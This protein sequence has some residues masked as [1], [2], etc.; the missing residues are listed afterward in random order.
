[1]A[2]EKFFQIVRIDQVQRRVMPQI[3]PFAG[4]AQP[5]RD[6]NFAAGGV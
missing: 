1:M 6:R 2:G 3:A 5:I 4:F